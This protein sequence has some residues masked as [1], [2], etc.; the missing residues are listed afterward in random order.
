MSLK[1]LTRTEIEE[2]KN[3]RHGKP[4]RYPPE[5]KKKHQLT[6]PL[7]SIQRTTIAALDQIQASTRDH[8]PE[9]L[10]AP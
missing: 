1:S 5:K 4:T 3:C 6:R 2:Y 7:R 9:A 10:T 8:L